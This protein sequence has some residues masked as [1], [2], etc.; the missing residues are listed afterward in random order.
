E[1]PCAPGDWLAPDFDLASLTLPIQL[2]VSLPSELVHQR[3]DIRGAEAQLHAASAQIG[4]AT[5]QL[6]PAITLSSG[7]SS[8]ALDGGSLFN[9]GGLIW[10]TAA[11]RT[12]Q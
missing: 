6:Y 8:T 2:P 10:G 3:P 1:T 7:I 11:A 9:T 5:A 4:I 12:H